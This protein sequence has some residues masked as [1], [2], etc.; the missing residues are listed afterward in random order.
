MH[1]YLSEMAPA[2]RSLAGKAGRLFVSLETPLEPEF[3]F[4][5]VIICNPPKVFHT[6]HYA[7]SL[8]DSKPFHYIF[9]CKN[10]SEIVLGSSN[11]SV[12]KTGFVTMGAG[13]V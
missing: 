6:S 1:E 13:A 4:F 12:S 3:L 5:G 8:K 10:S 9:Y 2:Q 7:L 11:N